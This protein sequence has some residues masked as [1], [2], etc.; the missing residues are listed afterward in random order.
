MIYLQQS[1]NF[2]I[3]PSGNGDG[4]W[5]IQS[6]HWC[7][8]YA[9]CQASGAGQ[10]VGGLG[11]ADLYFGTGSANVILGPFTLSPGQKLEISVVGATPSQTATVTAF[12][13]QGD[14][15]DGS[16]LAPML[17][18]L[19]SALS[20]SG[21]FPVTIP[22]GV[23]VTNTVPVSDGGLAETSV[24]LSTQFA[25]VHD[26]PLVA[27]TT[28]IFNVGAGQTY[29]YPAGAAGWQ[30]NIIGF[31]GAGVG[32]RL[33]WEGL[34]TGVI[35]V[36]DT[37]TNIYGM[38]VAS[39]IVDDT[40]MQ[41]SITVPAGAPATGLTALLYMCGSNLVQDN[42]YDSAIYDT[43]FALPEGTAGYDGGLLRLGVTLGSS[44]NVTC[45]L[46]TYRGMVQIG[47]GCTQACHGYLAEQDYLG[48]SIANDM[49]L[50]TFSLSGPGRSNQQV[51]TPGLGSALVLLNDDS[52]GS[53]TINVEVRAVKD[54][55]S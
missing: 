45:P 44:G 27:G 43:S 13:L 53:N 54:L 30:M 31:A 51:Y 26:Q 12:G 1:L 21:T 29:P 39:G 36:R 16:D 6:G 14:A 28:Q 49:N 40:A 5:V 42:W 33:Q 17:N 35:K 38:I 23:N 37:Q 47:I 9:T 7:K 46:P 24:T 8:V 32:V 20:L 25:Q 2:K 10:W 22:A 11:G 3:P 15:G 18:D 19:A 52:S 41:F 55:L 48:N 50:N 34:N 4:S